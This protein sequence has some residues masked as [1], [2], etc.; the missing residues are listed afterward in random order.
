MRRL[1][2]TGQSGKSRIVVG[3]SL[4]NTGRYLPDS[5]VVIISDETVFRLYGRQFPPGQVITIGSGE[6][7]KTLDTVQTIYHRLI[8][9]AADRSVF[10]LGIGGG[11]VCD[12]TG[13]VASTYLRGVRFGY[14]ATTLL[15]QVDASVGGKTGVNFMG[16]KNMVGVFNQPDFVICDPCVLKTLPEAELA[17]GFAE[18]VKHAAI[19]DARYFERLE[20]FRGEARMLSPDVIEQIIYDSVAIKS[21][22]VN[23]DEKESGERRKLNFGHTLGHAIEKTLGLRHGEAVS[24]GMMAAARLSAAKGLLAP[25]DAVRL[26]KLLAALNLPTVF[27]ADARQVVEALGR[28]KKRQGDA[29]FFVLLAGIG[30]AVIESIPLSVLETALTGGAMGDGLTGS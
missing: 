29:L 4:A 25:S 19:A 20:H 5:T 24:L 11:I 13:F 23:R 9:I 14:V 22:V 28:D 30:K 18:I 2:I 12:I 27:S 7:I 3:E 16:Y 17:S 10:L 6:S 15:A 8:G 21:D 1:E 26:E